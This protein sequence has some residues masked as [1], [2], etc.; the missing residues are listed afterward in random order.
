MSYPTAPPP[1]PTGKPRLRGRT[2]LRLAIILLVLGVAGLIVGGIVAVN[3]TL[4]KVDNFPRIEVPTASGQ[5]SHRSVTLGTGG[6][7]AYYESADATSKRIPS[8]PVTYQI[9]SSAPVRLTTP[10]GGHAGQ[11]AVK[12]LTYDYNGHKGVALWQ[13]TVSRAGLYTFVVGASAL[14]DSDAHIAIGR[15]IGKSTAVG[16]S[17][18]AVG[19]L[20]LIAGIVLLIVGLVKRSRHKNELA[21]VGSGG[22]PPPPGYPGQGYPQPGYPQQGYPQQGYPQQNYPQQNY[23]Q[24]GQPGSGQPGY[25]PPPPQG[26]YGQQPPQPGPWPPASS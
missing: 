6:Y 1:G 21:A 17:L 24:P 23:P 26:N 13:F 25:P 18:I 15:S 12:S 19:V 10:Y 2:P 5:V 9:G 11:N 16:A 4:K 8:I 22:Y 3:G 7:V 14:A 20:L